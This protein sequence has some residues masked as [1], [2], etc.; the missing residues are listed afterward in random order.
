MGV[1]TRREAPLDSLR[2]VVGS[3]AHRTLAQDVAQR[4][5]TLVRDSGGMVPLAP[6]ARVAIVN[7]MAE[8]ELKAGRAFSKEM[9]K[10]RA[11]VRIAG[12]ISPGTAPSQLDSLTRSL[13][14]GD[15]VVIAVYVRRVEGE[16]RTTVPPSVAAWIDSVAAGSRAVIVAFGNPYVM[17]QFPHGRAYI[18]T[19]GIGDA[20]EIAAA[21][22]LAGMR[23]IGG[24]SPVSLP[25][26]F[27]RGDG[28]SR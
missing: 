4:A 3:S 13:N 7:Y 28:L 12:K 5:I 15:A 9:G 25:G 19:Y 24:K 20:L 22:A 8:T 1:V 10:L 27:S 26:F 21:R 18:N 16:G 6:N 14:D 17:R 11:G 23:P 2:T